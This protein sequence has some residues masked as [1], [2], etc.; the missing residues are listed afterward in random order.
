MSAVMKVRLLIATGMALAAF[1]CSSDPVQPQEW[2]DKRPE[3]ARARVIECNSMAELQRSADTNCARA[4]A[5][6]V[7]GSNSGT[8]VLPPAEPLFMRERS[9]SSREPHDE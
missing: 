8:E 9:R 3:L 4:L 7:R 2:W 1:G 5:A 6:A